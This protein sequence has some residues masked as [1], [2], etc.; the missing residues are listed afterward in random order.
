VFKIGGDDETGEGAHI[1]LSVVGF[2]ADGLQA[3]A[4]SSQFV[5]CFQCLKSNYLIDSSIN[6]E[7]P[8]VAIN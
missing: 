6:Q 2:A 4:R 3:V 1:I 8:S 5:P 7:L